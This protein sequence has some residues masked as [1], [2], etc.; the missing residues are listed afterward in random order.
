[1]DERQYQEM[2][3]E[4][5]LDV[6]DRI[7]ELELD[8]DVDTSGGILTISHDQ[9]GSIILSRQVAVKEIWVAA[10]SGGFHLRFE[11]GRWFCEATAEDFKTLMNRVFTEQ[12]NVNLLS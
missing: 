3:D 12:L 7:D 4:I 9:G 8:V 6:E 10:R 1:M 11:A 2:V 5:F